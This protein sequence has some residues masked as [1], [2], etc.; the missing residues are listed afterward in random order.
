MFCL[1]RILY[2]K[3]K[4][5]FL[6]NRLQTESYWDRFHMKSS[7]IKPELKM[8][9]NILNYLKRLFCLNYQKKKSS[10]QRIKRWRFKFKKS[11]KFS[12]EY[13]LSVNKIKTLLQPYCTIFDHPVENFHCQGLCLTISFMKWKIY[14]I[15]DISVHLKRYI[16]RIFLQWDIEISQCWQK[17]F[18]LL[19]FL[20]EKEFISCGCSA[21]HEVHPLVMFALRD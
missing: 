15:L 5:K 13:I 11:I 21:I 10:Y 8:I 9:L 20:W 2:S 6:Y 1:T 16:Y 7:E 19:R 4:T 18:S 14:L 3:I 12:Y 17:G